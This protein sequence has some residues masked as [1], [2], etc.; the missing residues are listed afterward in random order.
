VSQT[1]GVTR[2]C[3]N[4]GQ[5]RRAMVVYFFTRYWT[6]SGLNGAP[7][8]L[9]GNKILDPSFPCSLIHAARTATV[10]L[11]NGVH[12]SFRPFPTHLT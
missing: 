4:E 7:D 11:A 6:E 9:L 8:L 2:F 10:G 1:Y 12:R 3:N 5:L